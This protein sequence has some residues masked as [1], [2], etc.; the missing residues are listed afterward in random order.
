[1]RAGGVNPR[2]RQGFPGNYSAGRPGPVGTRHGDQPEPRPA[3][4]NS[5]GLGGSMLLLTGNP[6]N[7]PRPRGPV[8]TGPDR[9]VFPVAAATGTRMLGGV[10]TDIYDKTTWQRPYLYTPTPG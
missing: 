10:G 2:Q 9:S 3:M 4:G 7:D 5:A 1:M 8:V 6:M